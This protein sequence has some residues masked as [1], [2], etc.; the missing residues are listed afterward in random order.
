MA[1]NKE[2]KV[3]K[4]QERQFCTFWISNSYFG[5]D[6]ADVKEISPQIDYT[7][8]FHAPG[9]VKGYM[10]IRGQL[11]LLIDMRMLMGFESKEV[12]GACRSILFDSEV[13]ESFAILVDRI[14]DIKAVFED[15]IENRP[16]NDLN[17]PEGREQGILD[18]MS[19]VCKLKDEL[20]VIIDSG[21]I[22]PLVGTP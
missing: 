4:T 20:L 2:E 5:V 10:N 19:G 12:D 13:G 3:S 11:F 7:P 8:I 21:K 6:I 15:Q 1:D 9:E 22:L 17:L 18:C 14:G 16:T